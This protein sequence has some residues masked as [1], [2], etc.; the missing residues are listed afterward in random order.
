MLRFELGRINC[1]FI[2]LLFFRE[3]LDI[4]LKPMLASIETGGWYLW[5]IPVKD[6]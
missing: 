3:K 4:R 5:L 1:D 6:I 2:F